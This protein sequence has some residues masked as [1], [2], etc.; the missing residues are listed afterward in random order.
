MADAKQVTPEVTPGSGGPSAPSPP[1]GYYSAFEM[2]MILKVS[3]LQNETGRFTGTLK[4]FATKN[5]IKDTVAPMKGDISSMKG[6][7]SSINSDISIIKTQLSSS[8]RQFNLLGLFITV[9]IMLL[10]L[11]VTVF[12]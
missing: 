7:I 9:S 4:K 5:D 3:K 1:A 2:E 8:E 12:K 6:D 11:S 10:T